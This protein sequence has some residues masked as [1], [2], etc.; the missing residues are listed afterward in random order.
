MTFQKNGFYDAKIA[1]EI[2]LE[3]RG[4]NSTVLAEINS[5][6]TSVDTA[7]AANGLNVTINN[8]TTMTMF[9][10]GSDSVYYE[11]W[12]DPINNPNIFTESEL[13]L[14]RAQMNMV[15]AYFTRLGY[16]IKR[17]RDSTNNRIN[18]VIQW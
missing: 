16:V 18:W 3:G 7:A 17:E 6:E 12:N 13:E 9:T 2:A 11:A 4:A 14:A 5:L 10:S 1:R 8:A 15:I